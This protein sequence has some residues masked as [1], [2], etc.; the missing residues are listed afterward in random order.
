MKRAYAHASAQR[1]MYVE[2]PVED[3]RLVEG[4]FGRLKLALYGTRDAASLWQE[5]L[6]DHLKSIGFVRGVSIPRVFV[7]KGRI[8]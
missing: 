5:C 8:V 3:P 6:A 1:E 7:H 2:V 4:A